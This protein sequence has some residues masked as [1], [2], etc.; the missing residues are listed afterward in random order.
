[1]VRGYDAT[2]VEDAH[3]T[4]DLSEWGAPSPDKVISHTNMYWED[5]KAPGRVGG[6]VKTADVEFGTPG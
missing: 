2:L 5:Q 6:V 4:E 3:T 1:L